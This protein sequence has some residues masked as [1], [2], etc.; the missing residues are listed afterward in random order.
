MK[1]KKRLWLYFLPTLILLF[2]VMTVQ[3]G[4]LPVKPNLKYVDLSR[5]GTLTLEWEQADYSEGYRIQYS[6]SSTFT[7]P[8]S[9]Y[10]SGKSTTHAVINNL[11]IANRYYVRIC[12]YSLTN[13]AR[14]VY[15]AWSDKKAVVAAGTHLKQTIK[16]ASSVTKT[17]SANGKFS[18]NASAVGRLTYKSG[19]TK[20]ATVSSNGTVTM[21]G[22]GTVTIKVTAGATSQYDSASKSV[23]LTVLPAQIKSF[24]LTPVSGGLT[25]A[26]KQDT[27]VNG[28]IIQISTSKSFPAS[29]TMTGYV[30][31]NSIV[32][33][34]S[35]GLKK[36]TRYYV[37][38]RSYRTVSGKKLYGKWSS[39]KYATTR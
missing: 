18:L 31:K 27:K 16:V 19:N 36:S 8:T 37:R 9:R 25:I 24:S 10:I 13:D 14:R 11:D 28:Y 1:K 17:Y 29:K 33:T 2:G 4:I 12:G 7:S 15:G 6:T 30:N 22:C 3:A 5:T 32:K 21:K 23:T 20:V 39:V 26:W 38:I 35:G 34:T